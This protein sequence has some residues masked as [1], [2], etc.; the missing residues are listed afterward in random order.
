MYNLYAADEIL[1]GHGPLT[2]TPTSISRILYQPPAHKCVNQFT[3]Y[4]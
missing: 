1:P 4:C 2:R 3:V